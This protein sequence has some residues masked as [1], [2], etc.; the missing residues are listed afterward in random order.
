MCP[1]KELIVGL[2]WPVKSC[3]FVRHTGSQAT[4]LR[5]RLIPKFTVY[6]AISN[7]QTMTVFLQLERFKKC[8]G[9]SISGR[10]DPPGRPPSRFPEQSRR[11]SRRL[12][13]TKNGYIIYETALE[14][15]AR[16]QATQWFLRT[17]RH[18]GTASRQRATAT[19]QRGWNGQPLGG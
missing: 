16:S 10:D 13:P 14:L 7:A 4:L 12:D 18:D 3:K 2:K 19:G 9:H 1:F 17:S 5:A 15:H 6:R 8:C 11:S